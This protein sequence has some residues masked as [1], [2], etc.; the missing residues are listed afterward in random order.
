LNWNLDP[1]PTVGIV[2]QRIV[3]GRPKSRWWWWLSPR[4]KT[5]PS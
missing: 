4:T 2:R 3:T 1:E 5:S